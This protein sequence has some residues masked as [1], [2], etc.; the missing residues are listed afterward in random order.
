MFLILLTATGI[1]NGSTYRLLP[2]IFRTERERKAESRGEGVVAEV[3]CQGVKEPTF[4]LGFAGAIA[5]YGA[6][7]SPAPTAPR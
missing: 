3:A 7:S 6:S 1:G 2:S 4:A 5:A